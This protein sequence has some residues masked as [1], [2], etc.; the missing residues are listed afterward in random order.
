M[1]RIKDIEDGSPERSTMAVVRSIADDTATLVRKEIELAR[2]ELTEALS[3]RLRAVAALLL[4]A[5]L[6]LVMLVFL[7][8][9]AEAALGGVMRGW[10]ARLVVVGG[11]V[12]VAGIAF[13]AALGWLRRPSLMPEETKRTVK[14]D[15]E[16]L[17]AQLK[18]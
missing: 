12:V 10:A 11:F 6:G 14:E 15:V 17:R 8:L 13:V 1:R 7:G 18:R 9:A 4:G 2:L 16:W 5:V 3:A